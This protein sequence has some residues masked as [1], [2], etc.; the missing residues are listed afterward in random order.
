MRAALQEHHNFGCLKTE[1]SSTHRIT[2]AQCFK[3]PFFSSSSDSSALYVFADVFSIFFCFRPG[4]AFVRFFLPSP[5]GRKNIFLSATSRED[6]YRRA[7][8]VCQGQND[9]TSLQYTS[10]CQHEVGYERKLFCLVCF[11]SFYTVRDPLDWP[12]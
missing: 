6:T 7:V 3:Q 4:G 1:T 10:S 2:Y 8:Q 9:N 11:D 12:D 5:E